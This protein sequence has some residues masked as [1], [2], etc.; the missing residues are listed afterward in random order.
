MPAENRRDWPGPE[1]MFLKRIGDLRRP[2]LHDVPYDLGF[3][4]L[5]TPKSSWLVI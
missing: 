5:H 2:L 3:I 4:P 1:T